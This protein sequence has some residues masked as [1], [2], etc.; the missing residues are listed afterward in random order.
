MKQISRR[1]FIGDSVKG[2]AV[3]S[4][5]GAMVSCSMSKG[6]TGNGKMPTRI[7]GKTGLEVSVL[8]FGG[9]SMFIKNKDGDWE[10]LMEQAL[11]SGINLFD[12]SPTYSEFKAKQSDLGSDERFGRILSAQRDKVLI[13]TKIGTRN[14]REVR[15][16]VEAS[17]SRLNTDYV[18]ILML[19]DL[20]DQDDLNDFESGIYK[21]M[22][23][24]KKAGI[25]RYIG[26]SSMA[27]AQRSREVLE[28]MDIDV[29]LLALNATQY[30]SYAELALPAARKQNTGVIAMKIM[31]N[32]VG[33]DA[34]PREL[35]KYGLSLDGVAS[36]VIGHV[37]MT[38]LKEN[39]KLAQELGNLPASPY[40]NLALETRL[41]G[42]AGPHKL[43]WA[44]PDY[45]DGMDYLI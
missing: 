42:Y 32:L 20:N 6:M 21:E 40:E 17:L 4:V 16:E 8:S 27:S 45:V 11:S 31:R 19:H 3:V 39:V 15:A 18:D 41:A 35:F 14:P 44:R 29:A 26:F 7:L 23:A 5:S 13:S 24:L 22:L 1:K 12:T 10:K 9:G 33:E 37:G 34:T 38:Q 2:A 25:A 36:G 43:C 30:G 28:R